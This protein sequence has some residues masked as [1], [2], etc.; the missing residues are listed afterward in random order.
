MDTRLTRILESNVEKGDEVN[1]MKKQL[2]KVEDAF[3]AMKRKNQG[4]NL[5]NKL[6]TNY[7]EEL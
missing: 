3:V 6:M 2:N 5:K 4:S 1:E 7:Q